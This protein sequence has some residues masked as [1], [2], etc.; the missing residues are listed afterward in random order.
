FRQCLQRYRKSCSPNPHAN[1]HQIRHGDDVCKPPHVASSSR[2]HTPTSVYERQSCFPPLSFGLFLWILKSWNVA[3]LPL[4][5]SPFCPSFLQYVHYQ[6][7][8]LNCLPKTHK[9]VNF[10]DLLDVQ[11]D[12]ATVCPHDGNHDVLYQ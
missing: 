5:S 2:H 1:V 6:K 11:H 12:H 10:L 7:G 9:T 3:C 4:L 8:A